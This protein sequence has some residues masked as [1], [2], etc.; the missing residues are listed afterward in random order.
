MVEDDVLVALEKHLC[1]VVPRGVTKGLSLFLYLIS[2]THLLY[3]LQ[4]VLECES[5]QL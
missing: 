5:L 2:L 4:V 3:G 1:E